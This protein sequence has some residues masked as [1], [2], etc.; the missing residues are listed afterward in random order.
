MVVARMPLEKFLLGARFDDYS[1]AAMK[2]KKD[3][4]KHSL[5]FGCSRTIFVDLHTSC[6]P[7]LR[8]TM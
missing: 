7:F 8:S 1:R 4:V 5:Q 3:K 2:K 6:Y